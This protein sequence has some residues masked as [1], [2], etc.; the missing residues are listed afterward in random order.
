MSIIN[1]IDIDDHNKNK[2]CN[3]KRDIIVGDSNDKKNGNA[4]IAKTAVWFQQYSQERLS[5]KKIIME[6]YRRW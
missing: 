5:H 4:A 2:K 3:R 1:K 6:L